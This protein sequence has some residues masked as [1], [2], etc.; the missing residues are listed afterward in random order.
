L[1]ERVGQIGVLNRALAKRD[2]EI[3]V[4]NQTLAERVGQ[5]GVLN[6]ALAKRDG[7]IKVLN[8]TLAERVGQIGVLNQTLAEREMDMG[9]LH[10]STSWIFTKPL[11]FFGRVLRGDFKAAF[12]F[13][14]KGRERKSLSI[15][16][17]QDTENADIQ[18]EVARPLNPSH[19]GILATKHTL[20]IAHLVVDRFKKHGWTA[21]IM[22][23]CPEDFSHDCYLV[24]CPQM[25]TKLPPGEKRIVFQMEQSVSSR[26][27]TDT[28]FEK[29]NSSLAV[30]EY[31]LV[32]IEFMEKNGVAYPHVHYLPVGASISYFNSTNVFE[33]KYDII[34][35][36]DSNSSC[37]REWL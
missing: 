10:S 29:L 14:T 15:A 2:G 9:R 32:N 27:F 24:I 19:W 22:T 35:Y 25:F 17:D 34:F 13:L 21:E 33:K 8:Q 37:R 6:R 4:L 5:I 12:A 20:F 36:G 1:A 3:K 16:K 26:W 30:L 28:Y 31:A 11:R 7:E 18:P 23:G